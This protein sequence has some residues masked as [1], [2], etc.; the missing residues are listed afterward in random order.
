MKK[1]F[2]PLDFIVN[3]NDPDIIAKFKKAE[4]GRLGIKSGTRRTGV[5]LGGPNLGKTKKPNQNI[6]SV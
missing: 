6:R 5:Y 3:I 1:I 2:H 4:E